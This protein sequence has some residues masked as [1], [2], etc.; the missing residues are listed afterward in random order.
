MFQIDELARYTLSNLISES[1]SSSNP[2]SAPPSPV[3][4]PAVAVADG[5]PFSSPLRHPSLPHLLTSPF[6]RRKVFH[7]SNP[8]PPTSSGE[9]DDP[10]IQAAM[11]SGPGLG[12]DYPASNG[13]MVGSGLDK[14]LRMDEWGAKMVGMQHTFVDPIHP[15][16]L[17]GSALWADMMLWE[18]VLSLSLLKVMVLMRMG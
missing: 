17:P 16:A 6:S 15:G 4:G 2:S 7:G 3:V 5:H 18:W 1:L 11:L 9:L 12:R 8:S 13:W 10:T 14:R